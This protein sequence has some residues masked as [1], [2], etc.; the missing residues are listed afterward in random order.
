M[1]GSPDG[2]SAKGV[3]VDDSLSLHLPVRE[4]L[5]DLMLGS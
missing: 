3:R 2:R 4:G 5:T 1:E